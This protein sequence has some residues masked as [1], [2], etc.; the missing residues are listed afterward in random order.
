MNDDRNICLTS[1]ARRQIFKLNLE[2]YFDLVTWL[3]KIHNGATIVP[4]TIAS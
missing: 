1:L 4:G 3:I 2:N